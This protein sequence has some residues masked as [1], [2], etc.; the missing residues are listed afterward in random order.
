[1]FGL[2]RRGPGVV[3][4]RVRQALGLL[5]GGRYADAGDLLGQL[6][7]R[8]R[9]NGHQLRSA[10]LAL[11]A[12]RAFVQAGDAEKA[13]IRARQAVRQFIV[14]GRPGRAIRVLQEAT[15]TLRLRG[16]NAQAEAL[17]QDTQ[18]RL[19]EIGLSLTSVPEES[20]PEP[21]G[22]LP[23]TCPQCGGPLRDVE[24]LDS[25]SAECP[26]CGSAVKAQPR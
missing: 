5:A 6:A 24:W 22:T 26:Y 15:A 19:A 3:R 1:M 10:R 20:M 17:E 18:A 4:P 16:W 2:R 7:D 11:E 9:D 23:P 25:L 21:R 13:M 8:T 12:G 14:G